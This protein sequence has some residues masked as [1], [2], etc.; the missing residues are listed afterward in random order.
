MMGSATN[1][2]QRR[3]R[4][5]MA[6]RARLVRRL[7]LATGLAAVGVIAIA[8]S[9][10]GQIS[11]AP[12]PTR[13]SLE[14]DGVSIATFGELSSIV[15]EIPYTWWQMTP[16]GRT[17]YLST[18]KPPVTT[19]KRGMTGGLE[20][21]AWHDAVTRGQTDARKNASLVGYS[22]EGVPVLRIRL[23]KAWPSKLGL[24]PSQAGQPLVET[25]ELAAEHIQRVAP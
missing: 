9:G 25:V 18:V 13:Y 12:V 8:T 4:S 17:K 16:E 3:V 19:L 10:S 21:W 6:N 11:V 14:I 1:A 2:P 15:E 22:A 20:L 23:E 24:A 5:W 7:A